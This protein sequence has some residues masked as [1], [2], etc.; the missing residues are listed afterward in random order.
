[1]MVVK[2]LLKSLMVLFL[3]WLV[4]G[5]TIPNYEWYV[6]D[7][8]GVFSEAQKS[9]LNVK[10]QEIE[11]ATSIEIAILVVP[12]VDDDINLAAVDVGNTRWVG[13]K[14]Q[15]NGLMLLIAVD[16]KKRSIQVGYGLEG[17]LPDLAT[18]QIGDVRFPP[19]FRQGNY[20]E[21]VIEMLDDVLWYI[22]QDPTVVQTY[23]HTSQQ[24]SW[25]TIH[26]KYGFYLLVLALFLL[27]A[28]GRLITVPSA[29][30][31]WRKMRKHG[32]YIYGG[33][34]LVLSFIIF[35]FIS[36]FILS[37]V[38]SYILL[39]FGVLMWLYGKPGNRWWPIRFGWWWGSSRWGGGFGWFWG[40]S[41]GGG[42]SSWG[43]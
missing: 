3:F 6:T 28:F 41:F 35:Y 19:N 21:W 11:Q 24:S 27:S 34:W 22:K 39:L 14:G 8:V 10:I 13:K 26:D 20:Y 9:E 36:T 32:W 38:I 31:I 16:D 7:K 2:S 25:N 29:K 12:T 15:D 37:A 1:M 4:Y 40:G 30:W 42:G 33:V 43:R 23:A 17:V 5:F 18:K